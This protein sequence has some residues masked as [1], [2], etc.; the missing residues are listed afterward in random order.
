[1]PVQFGIGRS[2]RY[3]SISPATRQNIEAEVSAGKA[4]VRVFAS[5]LV[6]TYGGKNRAM[7]MRR[8]VEHAAGNATAWTQQATKG[9]D[10]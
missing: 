6:P 2:Y 7:L 4:L 3:I 5:Y 8:Y 1:M 10:D 9:S